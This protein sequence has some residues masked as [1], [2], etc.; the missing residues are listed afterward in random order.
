[1]GRREKISKVSL[2]VAGIVIVS[3]L[4]YLTQRQERYYHL[5]YRELYFF[6]LILAGIW[7]GLRGAVYTS[8][9]ITLLFLPFIFSDW[10]EFSISDF[11]QVLEIFL[12]NIVGIVLG[13]ISDREKKSLK[14][15]QESETL[16]V[17]GR[18]ISGIV[19]D[20]KTPLVA[21]GGY[22]R[23]I[24]KRLDNEDPN[25]EK[26]DII[27]RE[28]QRLDDLTKDILAYARPVALNR[29]RQDLNSLVRD[30]CPIAAE[31]ANQRGIT[32]ETHLF[33]SLPAVN[34]DA[35]A[36]ERA[37]LNLIIN[38]VQ[39]SPDGTVVAVSTGLEGREAVIRIAD[40]GPG[41]PLKIREE[42]FSPFF[43]TKKEGTGLGLSIA[44]KIIRAHGGSITITDRDGQGTVFRVALPVGK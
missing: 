37:L 16:A 5:F 8:L 20:M 29:S 12:L 43:T 2:I 44:L 38:A 17:L 30:C 14:A 15:L 35:A 22:A 42:I 32:M 9:T 18:A 23:S 31:S 28:T 6:P 21:I 39:A 10:Q 36:L 19:H 25:H 7:F 41:I 24:K 33:P 27:V 13:L 4:H 26:L 34:I 11:D 1:L 40:E 3:L